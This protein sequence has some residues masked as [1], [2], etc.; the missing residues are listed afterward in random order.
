MVIVESAAVLEHSRI[1]K[2]V[3]AM[4]AAHE[5]HRDVDLG[6]IQRHVDARGFIAVDAVIGQVLVPGGRALRAGRFHEG[7]LVE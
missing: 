1:E 5:L 6:M 4:R 3:P 2:P 7:M